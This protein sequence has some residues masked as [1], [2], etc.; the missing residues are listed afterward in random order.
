MKLPSPFFMGTT[1]SWPA[2]K[3]LV[4]AVSAF[5]IRSFCSRQMNFWWSLRIRA[6]GSRWASVRIW[7]PLQMPSTGMPLLAASITSCITGAKRAMAPQR[8]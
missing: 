5:S 7:K 6:P 2:L 3:A 1:I 4:Q 8:R